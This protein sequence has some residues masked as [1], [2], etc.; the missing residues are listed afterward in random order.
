VIQL[1]ENSLNA[2]HLP[3]DNQDA[4]LALYFQAPDKSIAAQAKMQLLG[5]IIASAFFA[6]LRTRQQL[7]YNLGA[8]ALSMKDVPGLILLSAAHQKNL[9]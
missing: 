9:P 8:A 5:R 2:Q 3:I 6:D 4:A 7:G 1:K